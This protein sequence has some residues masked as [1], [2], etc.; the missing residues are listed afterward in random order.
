MSTVACP[1]ENTWLRYV[2]G[3]GAGEVDNEL[4][5][6]LDACAECRLVFAELARD[7]ATLD[8]GAQLGRYVVIDVLGRGGMGIVYKAFDPELD[9]AIALK[10][11]AVGNELEPEA[12]RQRL[13]REAKT[14]ARLSHPN[15]VTVHDVGT[16]GDRVFVAMEYVTGVTLRAWLRM[17]RTADEVIGVLSDAA[18]G[19]AAAHRLAIVH[20][21]FK[22][23]NVMVDDVGRARVLD[24]GLARSTGAALDGSRAPTGSGNARITR[25]GA[26]AGTPNYMAPEQARAASAA[27]DQFSFCVVLHEALYGERPVADA[28]PPA[29]RGIANRVRR[30]LTIG[31]RAD[32]AQ[33]YASMDALLDAMRPP[34]R[35]RIAI[36]A[37]AVVALGGGA[38]AAWTIAHAPSIDDACALATADVERV[39]NPARRA[40]L[41]ALAG[42]P[43][44]AQVDTWT[45]SWSARRKE[46]CVQTMKSDADQSEDIASQVGCLRRRLTE[47]DASMSAIVHGK[48]PELVRDASSAIARVGSPTVCDS[49]ER[50]T[51]DDALRA[52]W[53]PIVESVITAH[54]AVAAGKI[55]EAEAAAKSAV[56]AAR[57]EPNPA[58]DLLAGVLEV[59]GRVQAARKQ[60]KEA[61]ATLNDAIRNGTIA[62]EDKLVADAW[63]TILMM[64]LDGYETDIDAAIFG[65]EVAASKLPDDEPSRCMVDARSGAIQAKGD[66]VAALAKVE[67]ALACWQAQPDPPVAAIAEVQFMVGLLRAKR[68][69]WMAARPPFEAAVAYWGEV[70][71]PHADLAMAHE[72]LG[73]IALFAEDDTTAERHYQRSLSINRA[74]GDE[75]ASGE[76][77]RML[78]YLLVRNHRCDEAAPI[79]ASA[80][81]H[82]A[83]KHGAQSKEVAAIGV[84]EAM[85]ALEAKQPR[86]A[87]ALL[88]IAKPIID[89]SPTAN[90]STIALADFTLART[91]V[92]T[93]GSKARALALAEHALAKLAGQPFAIHRREIEAW[94]AANR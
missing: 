18:R 56:A 22:P 74:L 3:G 55:D 30:A 86:R 82:Q 65:A 58:P 67:R 92:A 68:T 75:A 66:P 15:V 72:Y 19:L 47:L 59:L 31:L 36:A 46:L 35:A 78:A 21:D 4:H 5:A 93:R 57:A 20:R 60:F 17:P 42:V 73:L 9:R 10:L 69:E 63:S 54:V 85:C 52:R 32:P 29:R 45:T 8:R 94:L 41:T 23:E 39:W 80:R 25:S 26:V 11:V 71:K 90:A 89:A 44:A 38:V 14:L 51:L 77:Q 34:R 53:M 2:D 49:Y 33:R 62:R 40:E 6:H 87:K 13:L 1:D 61:H 70:G 50:G 79:L 83:Q 12:A 81:V 37:L 84:G 76:T 7:E 28:R 91:L 43:V 24:F 64:V 88:D 16:I 27:S 48:L